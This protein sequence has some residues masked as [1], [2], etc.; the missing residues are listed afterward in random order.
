MGKPMA[1]EVPTARRIS[2]LCH[3]RKG[4]ESVPPPMPTR[5][6]IAPMNS[7]APVIPAKPGNCLLAFGFLLRSMFVAT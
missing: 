2:T 1:A 5:L 4:T 7:P 6:E 3:T